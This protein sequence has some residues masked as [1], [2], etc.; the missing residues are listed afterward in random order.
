MNSPTQPHVYAN[1]LT[2]RGF[3]LIELMIAITIGLLILA[4]LSTLFVHQS[5]VRSELDKSNRMIDNGRYAME[6][7]SENLKLAGYYDSLSEIPE[8]LVPTT[9]NPCQSPSVDI[10]NV[11]YHH[12]QGYDAATE[13][14]DIASPPCGLTSLKTGSDI[15]VLRRVSTSSVAATAAVANATYLQVSKCTNDLA[16]PLTTRKYKIAIAPSSFTFRKKNCTASGIGVGDGPADLRPLIVQTYFVSP[17]NTA[18][19]GIPTLMRRELN[20]ATGVF[21]TTPLVEGIEYFQVDYGLDGADT[22]ADGRPDRFDLADIDGAADAYV[23]CAACTPEEWANIVS[24]KIYIISRNLE[25]TAGYTDSKSYELGSAGTFGPLGDAYKRHVYTQ[26]VRLVNP[27]S[28]RE[29]P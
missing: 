2:Q 21:E 20:N 8:P 25:T 16:D 6:V 22:D 27:S 18:G 5:R 19:D 15:L 29:V 7:L 11:L 1:R 14:D 10:D 24:V 3:S 26:V 4:A 23:S 13:S 28:R 12:V 17:E 9:L